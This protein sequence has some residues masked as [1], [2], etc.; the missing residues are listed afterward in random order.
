MIHKRDGE[1]VP[2]AIASHIKQHKTFFLRRLVDEEDYD[3]YSL[4][5][6]G[7][8]LAGARIKKSGDF[9]TDEF[10]FDMTD[11]EDFAEF[12]RMVTSCFKVVTIGFET[13]EQIYDCLS[14]LG[15]QTFRTMV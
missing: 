10:I 8:N 13:P 2:I 6:D 1:I 5:M 12:R 11:P 9:R 4:Y 14:K 7:R 15:S 3:V